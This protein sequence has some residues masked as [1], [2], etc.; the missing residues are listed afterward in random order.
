MVRTYLKI[1]LSCTCSSD[2]SL[3]CMQRRDVL[4]MAASTL[5]PA[6]TTIPPAASI[7][8]LSDM[9]TTLPTLYPWLLRLHLRLP[10]LHFC[11][12]RLHYG[13]LLLYLRLVWLL[14][15]YVDYISDCLSHTSD[16]CIIDFQLPTNIH[17]HLSSPSLKLHSL[18]LVVLNSNLAYY[19]LSKKL[20]YTKRSIYKSTPKLSPSSH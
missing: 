1:Q 13:L 8:P 20:G 16:Y 5:S 11:L 10:K 17:I 6:T 3:H 12:L 14:F 9:T 19:H 15:R 7:T 2:R 18:Y 4:I